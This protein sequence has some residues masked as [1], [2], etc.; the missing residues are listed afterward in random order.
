[1]QENNVNVVMS[2]PIEITIESGIDGITPYIGANGN[3]YE[4]GVD[5]GIVA[6]GNKGAVFTPSVA[7]NS[8]LSWTNDGYLVNPATKNIRGKQGFIFTPAV[9]AESNLTWTND[10]E[11]PNPLPRNIKGD[12]GDPFIIVK[13]YDS[14][15]EMQEDY[16][17]AEVKVG[18]F[19]MVNTGNV[20]DEDTGKL[21]IKGNTQYDFIV[22]LSGMQ[23]FTGKTP[24]LEAGTTTTGSAAGASV[25]PNGVDSTG[26]PKYLLN[27]VIPTAE[28]DAATLAA[29]KATSDAIKATE[30]AVVS[31]ENANTATGAADSAAAAAMASSQSADQ[32]TAAAIEVA[33][34]PTKI[35]DDNYVYKYS[36][37]T[38]EYI[39][40]DVFVRGE[41][42]TITLGTV[43]TSTP[44]EGVN[45]TNSGTENAAIFNFAIPRGV[46][47]TTPVRGA[48]YW[49]AADIAAINASSKSYIDEALSATNATVLSLTAKI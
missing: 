12:T 48:D 41:A 35:G 1:M 4:G 5:S 8:D 37:E 16:V 17:S 2:E 42:A 10:G 6:R 26:N 40:T 31:T 34:N 49:T 7:D 24:V 9:D 18:Q 22:D 3:W 30:D 46:N 43:A 19:V 47:G 23:G 25:T 36:P 39:K 11:L 45:I 20:E 28:I 14:V 38:D 27:F 21:Y 44:E 29:K 32:A 13:V 33:N 15:V